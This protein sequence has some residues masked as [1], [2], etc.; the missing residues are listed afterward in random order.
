MPEDKLEKVLTSIGL[1][2]GKRLKIAGRI[3]ESKY[4][5]KLIEKKNILK[6]TDV[7]II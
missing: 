2:M 1:S 4:Q 3:Q 7:V 5:S 6:E